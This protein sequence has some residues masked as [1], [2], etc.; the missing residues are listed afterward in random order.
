MQSPPGTVFRIKKNDLNLDMNNTLQFINGKSYVD[1]TSFNK[2]NF[3]TIPTNNLVIRYNVN[4]EDLYYETDSWNLSI[5]CHRTVQIQ[6][7]RDTNLWSLFQFTNDIPMKIYKLDLYESII[8]T[9]NAENLNSLYNPVVSTAINRPILPEC[10]LI[11][12]EPGT[13]IKIDGI[14]N[15]DYYVKIKMF[16]KKVNSFEATKNNNYLIH[17]YTSDDSNKPIMTKG[18]TLFI[19]ISRPNIL[20]TDTQVSSEDQSFLDRKNNWDLKIS[21]CPQLP[22]YTT[23]DNKFIEIN[24]KHYIKEHLSPLYKFLLY[25]SHLKNTHVNDHQYMNQ[26]IE[27]ENPIKWDSQIVKK[28]FYRIFGSDSSTNPKWVDCGFAGSF[29]ELNSLVHNMVNGSS[30]IP[31]RKIGNPIKIEGFKYIKFEIYKDKFDYD[32]YKIYYSQIKY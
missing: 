12:S 28:T 2:N 23:V 27:Y 7:L 3:L 8:F 9:D 5:S 11:K 20:M 17:T 16:E 31:S 18:N 13:I 6:L 21:A 24:N 29:T 25:N 15:L 19:Y 14:T 4:N 30:K 22:D 26:I 10:L 1:N 32:D